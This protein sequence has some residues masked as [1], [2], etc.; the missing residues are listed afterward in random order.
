MVRMPYSCLA[1]WCYSWVVELL[2]NIIHCHRGR[3]CTLDYMNA[4]SIRSNCWC[5][6]GIQMLVL[7]TLTVMVGLGPSVLLSSSSWGSWVCWLNVEMGVANAR[8]HE[9]CF[10]E[11]SWD[12]VE[13]RIIDTI[14]IIKSSIASLSKNKAW[15]LRDLLVVNPACCWWVVAVVVEPMNLSLVLCY[16]LCK[17]LRLL[18]LQC[19]KDLACHEAV[20]SS[21]MCD[22]YP[23]NPQ[24]ICNAI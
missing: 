10:S 2:W 15:S 23:F 13:V 24:R 1:S 21:L 19:E 16:R 20:R 8:I 3:S 6:V 4:S 12:V 5:S 11:V 17:G 18:F 22:A 9:T 14:T 7:Q